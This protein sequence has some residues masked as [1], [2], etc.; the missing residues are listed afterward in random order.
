MSLYELYQYHKIIKACSDL[1][2]ASNDLAKA[3]SSAN[4]LEYTKEMPAYW[5]KP[6][7]KPYGQTLIEMLDE[8]HLMVSGGDGRK[9][10]V[11][12]NNVIVSA[13]TRYSPSD[14]MFAMI[15]TNHRALRRYV[16]LPHTYSYY[17]DKSLVPE[18][19]ILVNAHISKEYRKMAASK[20]TESDI[21][22]R[23]YL[24]IDDLGELLAANRGSELIEPLERILQMGPRAKVHVL[25]CAKDLA[26][27]SVPPRLA[28]YFKHRIVLT[29]KPFSDTYSFLYRQPD[30]EDQDYVNVPVFSDAHIDEVVGHWVKQRP[31]VSAGL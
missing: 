1:E 26:K 10:A 18:L 14:V 6:L 28:F 31:D 19:L 21:P 13:I 23:L 11:M 3:V 20:R 24:V 8:P 9:M 30:R 7:G 5:Y 17:D 25:A 29:P 22:Q 16:E 2:K 12:L 4:T 15:D 27:G